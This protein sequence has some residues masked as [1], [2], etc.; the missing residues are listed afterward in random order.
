MSL[1]R[2]A[3]HTPNVTWHS[4]LVFAKEFPH[5]PLHFHDAQ[6]APP[7]VL[8]VP[9]AYPEVGELNPCLLILRLFLSQLR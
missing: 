2:T 3:V 4:F 6:I 9:A 7:R 5:F 1:T 8:A